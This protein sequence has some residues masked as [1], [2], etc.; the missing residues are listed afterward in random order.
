MVRRKYI[1]KDKDILIN[2][3]SCVYIDISI[4]GQK[5]PNTVVRYCRTLEFLFLNIGFI[6]L[7]LLKMYAATKKDK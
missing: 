5:E 7:Y 2:I 3:S 4:P 6:S 1:D